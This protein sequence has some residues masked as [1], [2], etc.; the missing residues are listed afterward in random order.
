MEVCGVDPIPLELF[1]EFWEGKIR[2][3]SKPDSDR[4]FYRCE[5]SGD[6]AISCIQTLLP[7]LIVKFTQAIMVLAMRS[8]KP[9]EARDILGDLCTQLKHQHH[10]RNE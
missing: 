4:P 3:A 1:A 10:Q 2:E 8:C 6:R 9:G 5:I 7:H